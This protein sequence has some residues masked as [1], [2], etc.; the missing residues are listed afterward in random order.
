MTPEEKMYQETL[1]AIDKGE[2][3]RARDL[4]TRLIKINP[5]KPDYWLWM[6]A[7]V[8]SA[9]ERTYCLKEVLRLDP[10]NRSAKHGLILMGA[11][12]PDDSLAIPL[13]MQKRHWEV[14]KIE[15][16]EEQNKVST[17]TWVRIGLFVGAI[18]ALIFLGVLG[19]VGPKQMR[20]PFLEALF[21]PTAA[22]YSYR[23]SPTAYA[24]STVVSKGAPPLWMSLKATYTPTAVYINTPHPLE[25]YTIALRAFQKGDWNN[26]IKYMNQVLELQKGSPSPD[27][28]FYL[29]EAYRNQ[30]R[31]NDA[32][33]S[34]NKALSISADFAPASMGIGMARYAMSPSRWKDAQSDFQDAIEKDPNLFNAYLQLA[35]LDIDHGD[36]DSAMQ[37]L[38]KADTLLAN[39]PLVSF[40]RAEAYLINGK[41]DLALKEAKQANQLD[42]TYL[43]AYR[44][45][46]EAAIAAGVPA[47][48]IE[49]LK[50][51]LLYQTEDG[52]ALA[53]LGSAYAANQEMDLALKTFDLALQQNNRQYYVYLQ[54]GL[55]YLN[56][57]NGDLAVKDLLNAVSLK[58]DS[59][60]AH[61]ALGRAYLMT[62]RDANAYQEF[63]TAEA[64]V[65]SAYQH[66][67]LYYWRGQS[68]ENLGQTKAA[69][70]DWQA[71][72]ALPGDTIPSD[73]ADYAQQRAGTL[74]SP[75][76]TPITPT[77]TLTRQP[78]RTLRATS[79]RMPTW[80]KAPTVTRKPTITP[81][82]TRTIT[83]TPTPK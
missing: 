80:T 35:S 75:T 13:R 61:I 74:S 15:S 26:V 81:T 62:E 5:N 43:P 24:S 83:I 37:A 44:L 51:Y 20:I 25:A 19:T 58:N 18:A 29:G 48:A 28:Y 8:N 68:L 56:Q 64:Y 45:I 10:Q 63:S 27:I 50:T 78:T 47:D 9:R 55:V 40:Y 70:R 39:S 57:K 32:I 82:G 54:R 11:L 42:I 77:L 49:A 69:L 30:A 59:F 52:E 60:D 31:Y 4:L 21:R 72:L 17:G 36:G 38:A 33:S 46:G 66:A 71:L 41:P 73:W 79:T 3:D 67:E 53:W 2:R 16:G 7:M 14:S 6:S 1:A 12:P 22:A 23:M 76:V 65:Q 34:Y